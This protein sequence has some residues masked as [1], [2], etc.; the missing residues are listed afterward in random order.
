MS[1]LRFGKQ[2]RE[3]ALLERRQRRSEMKS[4]E[5]DQKA[6]VVARDGSHTCRLVPHC[7]ERERFETAHINDK[8]MGGDHGLRSTADQMVRAC[9]FHHQGKWS[10]HSGDLRVEFLTDARANGPI[11]VW[12]KDE[13]GGEYLVGREA[14]VGI[15]ERD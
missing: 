7:R 12:G 9:F 8:G 1:M 10:L 15:W 2:G 3:G 11:E 6:D 5:R 14:A 4:F 13:Q